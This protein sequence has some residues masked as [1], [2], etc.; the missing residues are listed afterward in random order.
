MK[1]IVVRRGE[2]PKAERPK[3]VWSILK[4]DSRQITDQV[5]SWEVSGQYSTYA[6]MS[7][8]QVVDVEVVCVRCGLGRAFYDV[9]LAIDPGA[10]DT[11][12]KVRQHFTNLIEE[13]G[14]GTHC[15]N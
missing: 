14:Y 4:L 2:A 15:T 9:E 13:Q 7:I 10:S 11:V 5:A 3:H 12:E 1:R 6:I 8:R